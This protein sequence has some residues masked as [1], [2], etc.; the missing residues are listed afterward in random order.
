MSDDPNSKQNFAGR[1]EG[2]TFLWRKG[3]W[4]LQ[5]ARATSMQAV[6]RRISQLLD[7]CKADGSLK[8]I[9]PGLYRFAGRIEQGLRDD[10]ESPLTRL[11]ALK[12][13]DGRMLLDAAQIRAGEQLR[14]DYERAHLSSR[15]TARY[16]A[17][18]GAGQTAH[19]SDNH[20]ETLSEMA[21]DARDKLHR[22]LEAVGP[23]L[24][25]ILL[26]VCCM[27]AG[28]EQA[29]LRLNLPRR[30]GKAILQM[31]LS[32]LSRHYGY[33]HAMRHAGPGAIGHWAIAD[34][35]PQIAT[36]H[37]PQP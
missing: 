8:E 2:A 24:S 21:L 36:Q 27:A 29:E 31:A 35:R 14:L 33:K 13:A 10:A 5:Q 15:V 25:G 11:A 6:S 37:A 9:A 32:R 1:M 3:E 23:E 20:I 22:A 30:A 34:F 4:Q 28:L 19:F 26:H 12:Q 17:G 18:G 16:D 7:F